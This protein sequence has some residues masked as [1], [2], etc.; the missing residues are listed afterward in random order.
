MNKK[1][2]AALMSTVFLAGATFAT[3]GHANDKQDGEKKE[4]PA[5]KKK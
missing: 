4:A 5:E 1:L 3:L 2:I